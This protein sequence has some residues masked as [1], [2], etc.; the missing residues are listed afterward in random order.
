MM[1][2]NK[3]RYRSVMLTGL[4]R[5]PNFNNPRVLL[6]SVIVAFMHHN[7]NKDVYSFL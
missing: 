5:V 4:T 1:V 6:I 3:S 2:D 7:P